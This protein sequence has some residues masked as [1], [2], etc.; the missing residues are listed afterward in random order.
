MKNCIFRPARQDDLVDIINIWL[1]AFD[2]A[3]AFPRRL[4]SHCGLLKSALVAECE[5][6][7]VSSLLLY[8]GIKLGKYSAC[9]LYA[10]C[11]H[12]EYTGRGIGSALSFFA[13]DTARAGGCDLLLLQPGDEGLER[14]YA[15]MGFRTLRRSRWK[16]LDISGISASGT[17]PVSAGEY[18]RH[19]SPDTAFTPEL[20]ASQNAIHSIYGGAFLRTDPG[21]LCAE[22]DGIILHI[23]HFLC[24]EAA[25]PAAAAAAA[26]YFGAEHVSRLLR[27][28]ENGSIALM[29][30][31]L[32]GS[33]PGLPPELSFPFTLD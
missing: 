18:L 29:A 30:L 7:V 27:D 33:F 8:P 13:A 15:G 19:L 5:G 16:G 9:Y 11:T 25:L 32:S 12:P 21:L 17:Q 23:R 14:W 24:D 31:P 22:F 4:L 1:A 20:I 6:R 10:L 2:D 26:K 28:D 3:P